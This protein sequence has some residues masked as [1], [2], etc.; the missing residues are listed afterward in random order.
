VRWQK[1]G[2][3]GDMAAVGV[4]LT[5]V[6]DAM[7]AFESGERDAR[8]VGQIP[9]ESLFRDLSESSTFRRFKYRKGGPGQKEYEGYLLPH[10]LEGGEAALRGWLESRIGPLASL[11]VERV[12]ARSTIFAKVGVDFERSLAPTLRAVASFFDDIG[13]QGE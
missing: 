13:K 10:V 1:T 4:V 6:A 11:D 3:V 2:A 8:G 9:K 7:K 5:N 12:K